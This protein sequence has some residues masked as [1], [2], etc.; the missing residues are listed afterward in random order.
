M[1]TGTIEK[2]ALWTF[3]ELKTSPTKNSWILGFVYFTIKLYIHTIYI[4]ITTT[5]HITYTHHHICTY[6]MKVFRG[7]QRV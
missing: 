5:L 2:G 1:F 7:R 3:Q 6:D 4:S